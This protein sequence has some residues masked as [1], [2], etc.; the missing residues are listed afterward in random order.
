MPGK[1]LNRKGYVLIFKPDHPYS[2]KWGYIQ[3]SRVVCEE[4]NGI[5]FPKETVFH[6]INGVHNDDRPDNLL[7]FNSSVEHTRYHRTIR[8]LEECGNGNYRKCCFCGEYGDPK[9]KDWYELPNKN[10]WHRKCKSKYDRRRY[11]RF[12][13]RSFRNNVSL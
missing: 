6:H 4:Y 11:E 12:G 3:R 5:I 7:I 2:S 10:A 13:V 8:A 1:I 9:E